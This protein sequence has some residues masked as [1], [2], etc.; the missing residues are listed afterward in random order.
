MGVLHVRV[1]FGYLSLS[2]KYEL[3]YKEEEHNLGE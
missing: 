3:K 1:A 2:Q